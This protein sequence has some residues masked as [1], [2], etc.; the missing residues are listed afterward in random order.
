MRS[1]ERYRQQPVLQQ[2]RQQ[3]QPATA[4]EGEVGGAGERPAGHQLG[5][6]AAGSDAPQARRLPRGDGDAPARQLLDTVH[7]LAR[8]RSPYAGMSRRTLTR[9]F[10][11]EV[12]TSPA[13]WLLGQRIERARH[14]LESTDL[15]VDRVAALAGF[16]TAGSLRR[17]LHSAVGVTPRGYRQS[18]AYRPCGA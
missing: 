1:P 15:T 5:H 16:G 4:V 9:R 18:V 14:L 6:L 10:R 7:D 12:G 17:H 13:Q 11:Q 8:H 3:E 2:G